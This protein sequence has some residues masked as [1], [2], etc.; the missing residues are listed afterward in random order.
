MRVNRL[1]PVQ[2]ATYFK[3]M[4]LHSNNVLTKHIY[5]LQR[6]FNLLLQHVFPRVSRFFCLG[7][8]EYLFNTLVFILSLYYSLK[9]L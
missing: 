6:L 2:K 5:S 4:Q 7:L 8:G 1:N 9:M 3:K